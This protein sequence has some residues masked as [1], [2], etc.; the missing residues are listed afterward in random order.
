[1]TTR[2]AYFFVL[3][4]TALALTAAGA[5]RDPFW[6][7][8]YSP[9]QPVQEQPA[10]PDVIPEAAPPPKPEPPAEKPVTEAE[11]AKARKALSI[12]GFT[13]SVKP[14][15]REVRILALINR[16]TYSAGD[17]LT[18]VHN[19]MRFQWKVESVTERDVLLTPSKA[20]RIAAKPN[21]LKPNL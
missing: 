1:M 20:E 13:K 14:E 12:S 15:T 6:P 3:S 7:I 19:D 5:S 21:D 2:K 10:A 8:G 17:T 9:P 18:F 16:Q 11:W 4:L